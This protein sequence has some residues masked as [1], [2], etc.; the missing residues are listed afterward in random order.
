MQQQ[1]AGQ[2]ADVTTKVLCVA[3]ALLLVLPLLLLAPLGAPRIGLQAPTLSRRFGNS[4]RPGRSKA[5]LGKQPWTVGHRGASGELPEVR[6]CIAVHSDFVLLCAQ[7]QLCKA[8][9]CTI[10]LFHCG[11]NKPNNK[12]SRLDVAAQRLM[13]ATPAANSLVA[14]LGAHQSADSTRWRPTDEP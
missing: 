7:Q 3:A 12:R 9:S 8:V 14:V 10:L 4:S 5:P 6:P 11:C 13:Q 2:P 1:Q